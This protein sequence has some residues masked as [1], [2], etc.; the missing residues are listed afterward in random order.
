MNYSTIDTMLYKPRTE[1]VLTKKN[2]EKSK[3]IKE[4]IILNGSGQKV[5]N[6]ISNK[7]KYKI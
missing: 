4:S 2:K 3:Y 1:K 5:Y 7:P 6:K